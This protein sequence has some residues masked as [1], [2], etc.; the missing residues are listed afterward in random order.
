MRFASSDQVKV[1]FRS[2]LSPFRKQTLES[3]VL[4]SQR[5]PVCIQ[6]HWNET[7]QEKQK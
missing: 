1:F 4:D 5:F 2:L 3:P 7:R 6:P